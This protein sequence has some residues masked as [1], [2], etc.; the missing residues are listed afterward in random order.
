MIEEFRAE[1]E[2]RSLLT[3]EE[4]MAEDGREIQR[5]L[6]REP[7]MTIFLR[8]SPS[9]HMRRAQCLAGDCPS[10]IRNTKLG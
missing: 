1:E 9:R 10:I 6:E 5:Q 7:T 3:L 8:P 2:R 4:R